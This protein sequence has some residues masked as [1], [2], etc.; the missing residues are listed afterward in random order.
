MEAEEVVLGGRDGNEREVTQ[1]S[2]RSDDQSVHQSGLRGATKTAILAELHT[3]THTHHLRK[4]LFL[5][6]DAE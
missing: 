6:P 4:V 3:P 5:P 2:N 1:S